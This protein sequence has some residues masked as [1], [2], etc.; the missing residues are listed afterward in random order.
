[1]L[2]KQKLKTS[3]L[4]VK[5][6]CKHWL[7]FLKL[8]YILEN[9]P[10]WNTHLLGRKSKIHSWERFRSIVEVLLNF[11]FLQVVIIQILIYTKSYDYWLETL[12]GTI[13]P[14]DIWTMIVCSFYAKNVLFQYMNTIICNYTWLRRPPCFDQE[15]IFLTNI[16]MHMFMKHIIATTCWSK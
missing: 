7:N 8:W 9:S 3:L 6:D 11:E 14:S 16:Q 5:L 4:P 15:K 12:E 2:F 10:K 1:M 13:L